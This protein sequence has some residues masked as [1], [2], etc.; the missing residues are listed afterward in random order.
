[1]AKS[2]RIRVPS[3]A[4]AVAHAKCTGVFVRYSEQA[5]AHEGPP[6]R[7]FRITTKIVDCA[8]LPQAKQQSTSTHTRFAL[9]HGS[10][11]FWSCG[12]W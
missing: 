10:L 8:R 7:E 2:G 6:D 3:L 5:A 4:Q 11:G 12:Y 1:M 9:G